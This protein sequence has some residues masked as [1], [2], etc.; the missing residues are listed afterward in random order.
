MSQRDQYNRRNTF[1]NNDGDDF[2][3][4]YG[5]YDNQQSPYSDLPSLCTEPM[6]P[7]PCRGRHTKYWFNKVTRR[8]ESFIYGGCGKN[9]NHF[10]TE[11]DCHEACGENRP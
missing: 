8:C 2:T 11:A 7:G 10:E 6:Q 3:S 5:G 4:G 1:A 9:N